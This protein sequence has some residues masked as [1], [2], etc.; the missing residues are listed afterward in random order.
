ETADGVTHAFLLSGGQFTSF[1]FPGA[2]AT[3]TTGFG[4]NPRGEI[5]GLYRSFGTASCEGVVPT[6][7]CHG[8]LLRRG[9]FTSIDFP[10]STYSVANGITPRG[11]VVA[12]YRDALGVSHGYLLTSGEFASIDVPGATETFTAGIN[13]RGDI[14]GRYRDAAGMIHGFLLSSG[15]FTSIDF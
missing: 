3:R 8:Y 15:E 9:E 12:T 14:V 2:G 11:D 6:F 4:I 1:D 7:A 5:V 13:A 10:R